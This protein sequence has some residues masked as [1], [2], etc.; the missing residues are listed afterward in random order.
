MIK[1][2]KMMICC[3]QDVKINNSD[4]YN[5]HFLA[6]FNSIVSWPY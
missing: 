6:K 4:I 3:V 5:K 2:F 1:V